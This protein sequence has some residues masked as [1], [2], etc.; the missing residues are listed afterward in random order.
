LVD[1]SEAELEDNINRVGGA[2]GGGASARTVTEAI[3]ALTPGESSVDRHPEKRMKA[4]YQA[5]EDQQLP[6]LKAENP[7]LRLTQLKQM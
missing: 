1:A 3:L 2:E 4:A 6:R 7:A 5:F